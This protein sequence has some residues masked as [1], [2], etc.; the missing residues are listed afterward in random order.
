[1]Y[2]HFLE[3]MNSH[4]NNHNTNNISQISIRLLAY[5]FLS[6][7][8]FTSI[9]TLPFILKCWCEYKYRC[10]CC[11]DIIFSGYPCWLCPKCLPSTR[12]FSASPHSFPLPL[13]QSPSTSAL[14]LPSHRAAAIGHRARAC[15]PLL[16]AASQRLLPRHMGTDGNHTLLPTD[17][18]LLKGTHNW[19]LTTHKQTIRREIRK[20]NFKEVTT[21]FFL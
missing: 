7:F 8:S 12:I 3:L 2:V 21:A 10:L 20:Q 1:M 16:L 17:T 13:V 6:H 15:R 5:F 11:S 9:C 14:F 4:D 18:S 19:Q